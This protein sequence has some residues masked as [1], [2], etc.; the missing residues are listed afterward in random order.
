MRRLALSLL[1]AS[2]AAHA[3]PEGYRGG[4]GRPPGTT[5]VPPGGG[6]SLAVRGVTVE[7]DR[8]DGTWSC[9]GVAVPSGSEDLVTI[10]LAISNPGRRAI[11]GSL[12]NVDLVFDLDTRGVAEGSCLQREEAERDLGPKRTRTVRRRFLVP[13]GATPKI[14]VYNDDDFPALLALPKP[15]RLRSRSR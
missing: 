2:T 8:S 1:L 9:G 11:A 3:D 6:P 14:L 7:A 12:A 4:E 15:R 13:R 10:T 5:Y